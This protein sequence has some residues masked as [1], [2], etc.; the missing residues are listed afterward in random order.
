M[1]RGESAGV[2]KKKKKREREPKIS[3]PTKMAMWTPSQIENLNIAKV[4]LPPLVPLILVSVFYWCR[5][6]LPQKSENTILS[7]FRNISLQSSIPQLLIHQTTG[8]FS[9]AVQSF[10]VVYC[11]PPATASWSNPYYSDRSV[12]SFHRP[13][14]S[15]WPWPRRLFSSWP[16]P[17][18]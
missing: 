13:W 15:P 17:G 8:V 2:R 6:T 16:P 1:R 10:S 11:H 5:S 14:P 3:K 12:S 9:Y 18:P 4:F 7:L